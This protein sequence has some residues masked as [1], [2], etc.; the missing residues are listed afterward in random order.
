MRW[1]GCGS[2]AEGIVIVD[3]RNFLTAF[4]LGVV[5]LYLPKSYFFAPV[6][7][8]PKKVWSIKPGAYRLP[9]DDFSVYLNSQTMEAGICRCGINMHVGQKRFNWN[10][11]I[12]IA[13]EQIRKSVDEEIVTGFLTR[14]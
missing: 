4:G 7:G 13:A 5:G 8:W 14:A 3:R 6:G 10:E 11:T 9:D 1:R 2:R 12:Q